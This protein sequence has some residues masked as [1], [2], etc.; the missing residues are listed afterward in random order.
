MQTG[1]VLE[2]VAKPLQV[3]RPATIAADGVALR[4]P[5]IAVVITSDAL[6]LYF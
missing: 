6:T 3:E 4:L 5:T 1:S 2:Q